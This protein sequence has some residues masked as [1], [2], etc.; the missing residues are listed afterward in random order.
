MLC[1][2]SDEGGEERR[3]VTWTS[4]PRFG[5]CPCPLA[6]STSD[7]VRDG[8]SDCDCDTGQESKVS[9]ASSRK[10]WRHT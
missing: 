9:H 4:G 2:L 5:P 10:R 7:N 3:E 8:S 1:A 6:I